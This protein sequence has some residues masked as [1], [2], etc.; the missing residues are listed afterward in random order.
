MTVDDECSDGKLMT[1]R[2][3]PM[4]CLGPDTAQLTSKL[5]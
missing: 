4:V 2:V 5:S 1:F 3:K